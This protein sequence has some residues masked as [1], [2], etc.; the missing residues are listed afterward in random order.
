MSNAKVRVILERLFRKVGD[1]KQKLINLPTADF[2]AFIINNEHRLKEE[3]RAVTAKMSVQAELK[4][5]PKT[6]TFKIPEQDFFKYDPDVKNEV[7]YLPML[8]VNILL[9][10][11]QV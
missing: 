6:S 1:N 9:D 3:F 10:M 4:L 8:T 7:E 2:Y 11:Q 5:N